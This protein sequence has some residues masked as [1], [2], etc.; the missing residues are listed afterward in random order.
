[1]RGDERYRGRQRAA[2]LPTPYK[3]H[4]ER[5]RKDLPRLLGR[6]VAGQRLGWQGDSWRCMGHDSEFDHPKAS[7][8]G[9]AGTKRRRRHSAAAWSGRWP[10]IRNGFVAYRLFAGVLQARSR[11]RSRSAWCGRRC[12][13][14]EHWTWLVQ[15]DAGREPLFCFS[16][17]A[18]MSWH[19]RLWAWPRAV[20]QRPSWSCHRE[21]TKTRAPNRPRHD[22]LRRCG[23]GHA[24]QRRR[25]AMKS[26]DNQ[27]AGRRPHPYHG[28]SCNSML[29]HVPVGVPPLRIPLVLCPDKPSHCLLSRS[30]IPASS[31]FS[32]VGDNHT[33]PSLHN[34]CSCIKCCTA[35]KRCYRTAYLNPAIDNAQSPACLACLP[36]LCSAT[37]VTPHSNRH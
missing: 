23:A 5:H 33:Q 27:N 8:L 3:H 6:A 28:P 11:S 29:Q 18:A 26:F 12:R 24:D 7:L 30:C 16:E 22:Y 25:Q 31:P 34:T 13:C 32:N 9:S 14:I 1:M 15:E 17:N 10:L 2:N 20:H 21:I 37:L 36:Q 19:R 4:S 35:E